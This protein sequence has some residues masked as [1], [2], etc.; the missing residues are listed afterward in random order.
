MKHVSITKLC[1]GLGLGLA[2]IGTTTKA[3]ERVK[4]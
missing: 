1:S 3:D 2:L 4:A